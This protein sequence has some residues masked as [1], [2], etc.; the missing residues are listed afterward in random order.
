MPDE[1]CIPVM[2]TPAATGASLSKAQCPAAA[3]VLQLVLLCTIAGCPLML[4]ELPAWPAR[5][6]GCS[7]PAGICGILPVSSGTAGRPRALLQE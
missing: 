2:T 6:R 1:P 7:L 5:D 4:P 3:A